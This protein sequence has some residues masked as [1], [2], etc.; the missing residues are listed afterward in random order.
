[1][2]APGGKI[3]HAELG[4]GDSRIMLADQ[5]P[6]TSTKTPKELKGT[7][8]SL[9]MY[10]EDV[11]AAMDK[12]VEAGATVTMEA[13][14]MFW[15]DRFGAVTDP[16]GHMWSIATHKEDVSPEEIAARGK[17]AMAAYSS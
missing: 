2:D 11:D 8:V 3:G 17:A 15:G 1:M 4:I 14:D 7:T 13:D 10:S 16:Y 9:F 5:F 6:Q 12:A